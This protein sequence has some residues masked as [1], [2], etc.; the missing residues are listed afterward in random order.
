MD[1]KVLVQLNGARQVRGV[2]RGYDMFLNLVLDE[3]VEV[4]AGDDVVQTGIS[5]IRGNSVVSIEVRVFGLVF[6][7]VPSV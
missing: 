3:A 1:K 6:G 5:V 7:L 2:V 4:R